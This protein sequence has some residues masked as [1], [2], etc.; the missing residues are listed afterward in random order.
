M[1]KLKER[2]VS[3]VVLVGFTLSFLAIFT[4]KAIE[5]HADTYCEYDMNNGIS[6]Q[7]SGEEEISPQML[8]TLSLTLNGGN[9]EIWA[10]VKNDF[11]LFSSTVNVIVQLFYSY[12]YCEDYNQMTLAKIDS[13]DD[14]NMGKTFT[15]KVSTEGEERFWLARM[16]YREN[17]GSWSER[18]VSARYSA[19]GQY[20]SLT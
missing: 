6:L 8:V 19:S 14:L 5:V 1:V 2:I 12:S 13:I 20:I 10:T 9:G 17:N 15:V 3:I 18:V 4:N 7:Q 16:R 11:Q